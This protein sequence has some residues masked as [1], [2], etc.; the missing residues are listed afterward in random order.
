[1]STVA[2]ELPLDLLGRLYDEEFG[3]RPTNFSI[4]PVH[5]ANGL[6]R[7]LTG[8]SYRS[9]A[10]A[11][12]L[13]R[14]IRDQKLGLDIERHPTVR[15]GDTLGILDRYAEAFEARRDGVIDS[16]RVNNLRS[17]GFDVLGADGAVFDDPDKSS[18]TLSN[19]RMITRDPSDN[20]CGQF[21]SRLLTGGGDGDAATLLRELLQRETDPWTVL[22]LPL[23]ELADNREELASPEQAELIARAEH[24][25][26]TGNNGFESPTLR[27]LRVSFDRLARFERFGG[28]KLNSMRRLVLFGC[29]AIHVQMCARWSEASEGAPRPP[30]LF[31]MFDGA[32][33]SIRDAS[34]ASL[35]AAGDAI[36][37]RLSER[38]HDHFAAFISDESDARA[39]LAEQEELE[40]QTRRK[41]LTP[42][43]AR[44]F[45]VHLEA[46]LP[47][48]ESLAEAFLE[49]GYEGFRG[50][51][52]GFLTELGRRAG[53]L[54]PWANQGR[55]GKLQKRYGITAEFLETL[56]AATVDP[57]EP[58]D[59]PE[60]LERLRSSYGIVVGRRGD[61]DAVRAN[62]LNGTST[63]GTPTSIAEEDL[64]ANVDALRRSILEIGFA[65]AYADGQTVITAKPEGQALL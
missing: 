45:D 17:L 26:A 16:V 22:A 14:W 42:E 61:D 43:L 52:V 28:S 39:A 55:G 32:R 25:F 35:R 10:L 2:A 40:P 21:L 18:Y 65:K 38:I 3:L 15:V 44:R 24:L 53:Y 13:R 64:R 1:V 54:T 59:F 20:R 36:E 41:R 11:H 48:A 60:F 6:A 51:P 62:N 46:G 12:V 31:D 49:V 33:P 27:N 30:I 47:P 8:R 50:H 5:V 4:K 23:L 57:D 56:V 7:N 37:G 58:L 19:E 29:F 63:F 9:T 34:K